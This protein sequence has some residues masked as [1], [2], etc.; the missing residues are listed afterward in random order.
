MWPIVVALSAAVALKSSSFL[1][2]AEATSHRGL[3]AFG[4][5]LKICWLTIASGRY[6]RAAIRLP[7]HANS[8]SPGLARLSSGTSMSL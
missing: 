4:I 1:S 2:S 6:H 3:S 7:D 5:T 8:R